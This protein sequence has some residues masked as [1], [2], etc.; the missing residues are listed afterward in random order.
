MM[1][2]I[3]RIY[4]FMVMTM[5]ALL[6][7]VGVPYLVYLSQE[8]G[9]ARAWLGLPL[10]GIYI[11]MTFGFTALLF[12]ISD[13]LEHILDELKNSGGKKN[14]AADKIKKDYTTSRKEPQLSS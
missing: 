8:I 5:M 12:H 4:R 11:I 9:F 6:L 3:A 7:G 13:T 1:Q 14:Q 10:A 2:T